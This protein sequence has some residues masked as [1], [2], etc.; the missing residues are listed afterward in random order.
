MMYGVGRNG[1]TPAGFRNNDGC[2]G[3]IEVLV[4]G[5][6]CWYVRYHNEY[7]SQESKSQDSSTRARIKRVIPGMEY[8]V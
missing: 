6:P 4:P 1:I 5:V 8:L 7:S 3:M 2:R